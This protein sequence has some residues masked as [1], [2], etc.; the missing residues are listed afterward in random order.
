MCCYLAKWIHYPS[1][2]KDTKAH[3]ADISNKLSY[4]YKEHTLSEIAG[5]LG[6]VFTLAFLRTEKIAKAKGPTLLRRGR[7]NQVKA[8][9]KKWPLKL[10]S[11]YLWASYCLLL[12]LNKGL[13]SGFF[14]QITTHIS[15]LKTT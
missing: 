12:V 2:D 5:R 10:T 3:R 4:I 1:I 13:K 11:L 7:K 9:M 14:Y 8:L 6:K 15:F